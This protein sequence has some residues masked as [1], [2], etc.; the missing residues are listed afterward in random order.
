[1]SL[2]DALLDALEVP[3]AAESTVA[4]HDVIRNAV[5]ELDPGLDVRTTDYFAHSFVPD[6]VLSWGPEDARHE[7]Y[8]HLRFSVVDEVFPRDLERIGDEGPLFL[9]MTDLDAPAPEAV[10][11][12]LVA[13]T[14]AIE[15][16]VSGAKRDA[17][18]R[19][20][21]GQIVRE[22]TGAIGTDRA[23]DLT[24]ATTGALG[25]LDELARGGAPNTD[26]IVH[27]L[28]LL[29]S[30]LPEASLGSVERSWQRSWITAGG[31][32]FDFPSQTGWRP[33][34]LSLSEL[35]MVL[36]TLLDA[37]R[38]IDH[39]TWQRNAGHLDIEQ[40]AIAL[41]RDRRG[42]QL[43]GLAAALLPGWTAQ[44]AWA[45]HVEAE[46]FD[47]ASWV[48]SSGRL[49]LQLDGFRVLFADDGRHFKDK[50]PTEPLPD[51]VTAR[52]RLS[53]QDVVSV[54]LTAGRDFL[55][56]GGPAGRAVDRPM[57]E[58]VSDLLAQ[59]VAQRYRLQE[60]TVQ[61]MGTDRLAR[62]EFDRLLVDLDKQPAPLARIARLAMELFTGMDI[63]AEDA[64]LLGI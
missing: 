42:G 8:V 56:Y 44:W 34:L 13:H 52:E 46:L 12:A 2:R 24:D 6:L 63:N 27:A 5:R 28:Q 39:D 58:V 22:G 4:T 54:R 62:L 55:V 26:A 15:E 57:V 10:G 7:R 48:M 38:D 11:R 60:A 30:V 53:E 33:E 20:A 35:G 18:T 45:E 14:P 40:L 19:A 49:G 41:A 9:G 64:H 37:E 29:N 1:M 43:N 47:S 23:H 32:P 59:D 36:N 21:T 16:F 31:D 51:L 50:P 25:V 61:L 17:R 3:H